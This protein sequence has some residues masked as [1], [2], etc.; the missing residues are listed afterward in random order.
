[1]RPRGRRRGRPEGP[2]HDALKG[3]GA[4]IAYGFCEDPRRCPWNFEGSGGSPDFPLNSRV[5]GEPFAAGCRRGR[6]GGCLAVRQIQRNEPV[7]EGV[8]RK[9]EM[10]VGCEARRRHSCLAP[11]ASFGATGRLN[12]W[13]PAGPHPEGVLAPAPRRRKTRTFE[14]P[15]GSRPAEPAGLGGAPRTPGRAPGLLVRSPPVQRRRES[16]TPSAGS[17][18]GAAGRRSNRSRQRPSSRSP[19]A[20]SSVAIVEPLRGIE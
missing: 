20:R 18:R 13:G 7:W 4:W 10:A 5:C 3:S 2:P 19:R 6:P 9:L 11:L 17:S 16:G 12:G 8:R 1:M 14:D 15:T